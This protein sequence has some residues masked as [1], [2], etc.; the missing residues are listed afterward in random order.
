MM[1]TKPLPFQKVNIISNASQRNNIKHNDIII[2][3]L[4]PYNSNKK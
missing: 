3:S 2:A 4:I 1:N